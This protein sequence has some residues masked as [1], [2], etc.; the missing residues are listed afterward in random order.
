MFQKFQD[1]VKAVEDSG[2]LGSKPTAYIYMDAVVRKKSFKKVLK[3]LDAKELL[4]WINEKLKVYTKLDLEDLEV[5]V[6]GN[7]LSFGNPTRMGTLAY[8]WVILEASKEAPKP[9][10]LSG[11]DLEHEIRKNGFSY[12][13]SIVRP[14]IRVYGLK[15]SYEGPNGFFLAFHG[16]RDTAI[17]GWLPNFGGVVFMDGSL[18]RARW[19]VSEQ[20]R[21]ITPATIKKWADLVRS[22]TSANLVKQAA[23]ILKGEAE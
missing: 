6:N 23:E 10:E 16:R 1:W 5:R 14:P 2:A 4:S 8:G 19:V 22:K 9:Y 11:M 17:K 13:N 15:G 18:A 20:G 7:R 21:N 12:F 3:S